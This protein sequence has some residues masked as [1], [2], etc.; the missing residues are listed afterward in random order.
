MSAASRDRHAED[1]YHRP[2]TFRRDFVGSA[3]LIAGYVAGSADGNGRIR[4]RA[5]AG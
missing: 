2:K 5:A 1:I 3:N 4:S